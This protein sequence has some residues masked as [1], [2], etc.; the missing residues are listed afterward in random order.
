[1][2][3]GQKY[4]ENRRVST[5][6]SRMQ[7]ASSSEWDFL[8]ERTGAGWQKW[9]RERFPYLIYVINILL[10]AQPEDKGK[11]AV[12]SALEMKKAILK[13]LT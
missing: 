11:T 5:S 1:M 9:R 8:V 4:S 12:T 2:N 13:D 7:F 3:Q 6:D 10:R